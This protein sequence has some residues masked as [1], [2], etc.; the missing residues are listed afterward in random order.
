MKKF[1]LLLIAGFI[2]ASC[3]QP[4]SEEE[5]PYEAKLVIRGIIEDGKPIKDIYIGRIMPVGVPYSKEFTQIKDASAVIVYK[6]SLYT[7]KHISEGLYSSNLIAHK[8]EK[9]TLLVNWNDKFA[10]ADTYVP[11]PGNITDMQM[12]QSAGNNPYSYLNVT[13][14]ANGKECYGAYWFIKASN[15]TILS[16]SFKIN[17][18]T[19]AE[20][21]I[22]IAK[23]PTDTIPKGLTSSIF[24][25]RVVVFDGVVYDYF[26]TQNSTLL[27]DNVFGQAGINVNWNVK[28]DGI[29]MFVG[30]A[31]VV[32][33]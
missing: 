13:I 26:K 25:A 16:Q 31:E 10:T 32:S 12:V 11:V 18:I 27:T 17:E 19:V 33:Q 4:L 21:N 5:F 22:P 1:L 28:G 30:K 20:K 24:S 6:D 8:G 7:L 3:E 15:G 9:Y 14:Q 29:G 23:V 2:F